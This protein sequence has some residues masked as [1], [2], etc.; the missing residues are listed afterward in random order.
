MQGSA[1]GQEFAKLKELIEEINI[2][3]LTTEDDDGTLRSRPLQT[4]AVED[5]GSIW[6]F[7]AR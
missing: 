2:G 7:T 4:R 6:F 1:A 5:D 3:M